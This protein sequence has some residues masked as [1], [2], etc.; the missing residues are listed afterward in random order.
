MPSLAEAGARVDAA[1]AACLPDGIVGADQPGEFAV[2]RHDGLIQRIDGETPEERQ[3]RHDI[4]ELARKSQGNRLL[5]R[6]SILLHEADE[7]LDRFIDRHGDGCTCKYC[8]WLDWDSGDLTIKDCMGVQWAIEMF[9]GSIDGITIKTP[10]E[11]MGEARG[12]RRKSEAKD[13]DDEPEPVAVA[14]S[15]PR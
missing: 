1:M 13:A 3:A 9:L 11:V 12:R 4:Y 8:E 7:L 5:R 6:I 2:E 14:G 15:K 10:A